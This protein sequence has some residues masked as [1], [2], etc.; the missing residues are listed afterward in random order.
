[1]AGV[2]ESPILKA[3]DVTLYFGG[4]VA[5]NRVTLEVSPGEILAITPGENNA[6]G[7]KAERQLQET[8]V[9]TVT[10]RRHADEGE[11]TGFGGDN[12]QADRRPG[13]RTIAQKVG[14]AVGLEAGQPDTE[15]DDCRQIDNDYNH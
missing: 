9:R 7:Q 3:E 11:H 15:S 13:N 10:E 1:M 14:P 4:I 8:H 5:L 2:T 12:R 6:G